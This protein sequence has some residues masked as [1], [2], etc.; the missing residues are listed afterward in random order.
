[1]TDKSSGDFIQFDWRFDKEKSMESI[2]EKIAKLIVDTDE[3]GTFDYQQPDSRAT[4]A[5]QFVRTDRNGQPDENGQFHMW[6]R[7]KKPFRRFAD[8]DL[9]QIWMGKMCLVP[10]TSWKGW[11]MRGRLCNERSITN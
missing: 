7:F 4:G 10:R 1:M 6:T 9:H 5:V 2:V 8:R 11:A 3:T